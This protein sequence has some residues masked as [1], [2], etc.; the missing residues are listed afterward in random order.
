MGG[1]AYDAV[2]TGP[3]GKV[4]TPLLSAG[5]QGRDL[6]GAST[7]C[8]ACTEACPVEIPLAD[9]LVR[10]RADLR[11]PAPLVPAR[12]EPDA[13]RATAGD[14]EGRARRPGEGFA[15]WASGAPLPVA[16]PRRRGGRRIAFTAWSW[17][18]SAPARYRATNAAARVGSRVLGRHWASRAPGLRGWTRSRDLPLPDPTPFRE[19][20]RRRQATGSW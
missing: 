8:G 14:R 10:L 5:A 11:D 17:A 20:W 6:P 13:G 18:W 3:M 9:L 15:W 16:R 4:L 2:Y 19:R 7:L 1:H 12:W